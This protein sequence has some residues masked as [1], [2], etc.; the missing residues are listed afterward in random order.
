MFIFR[1][2]QFFTAELKLNVNDR[3][4]Y[5]AKFL[6][7]LLST[8]RSVAYTMD[9]LSEIIYFLPVHSSNSYVWALSCEADNRDLRG[10]NENL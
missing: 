7:K 9:F 10:K 8:L 3:G 2:I 6:R 1:Y 5:L 4:F